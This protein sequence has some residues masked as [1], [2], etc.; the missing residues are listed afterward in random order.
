MLYLSSYI[1]LINY[2]KYSTKQLIEN[3]SFVLFATLFTVCNIISIL[4]FILNIFDLD[5]LRE[6]EIIKQEDVAVDLE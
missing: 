5:V 2:T 4:I 1:P 6:N 3:D